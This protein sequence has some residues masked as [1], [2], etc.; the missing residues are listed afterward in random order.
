VA[1]FSAAVE[2]AIAATGPG[3]DTVVVTHGRA[4]CLYLESL[5][6]QILDCGRASPFELVPFWRAL[7]FPDAWRLDMGANTLIRVMTA[8]QPSSED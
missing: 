4:P 1:R 3:L 7:T 5:K 8:G 2:E 6:P